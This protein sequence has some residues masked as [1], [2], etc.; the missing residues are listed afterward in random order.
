MSEPRI[1]YFSTSPR[2]TPVEALRSLARHCGLP[3]PHVVELANDDR[4][5][6]LFDVETR[7]LKYRDGRRLSS[8]ELRAMATQRDPRITS[9][10]VEARPSRI[11][12]R[13]ALA[14]MHAKRPRQI[15]GR[16]ALGVM[17]FK[18]EWF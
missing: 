14:V 17:R 15:D 10:E 7:S 18:R 4:L 16:A 1:E 9:V 5:C 8:T 13:A 2:N 11:D 12:G 3:L 6:E